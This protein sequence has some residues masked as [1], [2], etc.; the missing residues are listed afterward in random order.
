VIGRLSRSGA[1]YQFEFSE[2]LRCS[3]PSDQCSKYQNNEKRNIPVMK[4]V[5]RSV[6]KS[7]GSE[8]NK[9]NGK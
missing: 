9:K 5:W 7:I 2:A 6:E 4:S 8:T 3:S 1:V